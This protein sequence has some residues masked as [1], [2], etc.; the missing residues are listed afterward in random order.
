MARREIRH[1]EH[2]RILRLALGTVLVATRRKLCSRRDLVQLAGCGK[3][4]PKI[5]S[6]FAKLDA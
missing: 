2:G 4:R 5:G 1:E 6:I 3:S